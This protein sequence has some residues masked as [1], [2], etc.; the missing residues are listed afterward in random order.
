MKRFFVS[1]VLL[2][3]T[4][5]CRADHGRY[6]RGAS[7]GASYTYVCWSATYHGTYD[8]MVT[9]YDYKNT[10]GNQGIVVGNISQT[11]GVHLFEV[12]ILNGAYG[13][14]TLGDV[15]GLVNS[16]TAVNLN[17]FVG[18]DAY[19][20]SFFD[21][22]STNNIYHNNT[23]SGGVGAIG[24]PAYIW[25]KWDGSSGN[26]WVYLNGVIQNSGAPIA[27]GVTGPVWPAA[28][29]KMDEYIIQGNPAL[30]YG[31]GTGGLGWHN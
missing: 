16:Q 28:G 20:W 2:L 19:G 24:S 29:N 6:Y 5:L 31:G 14:G 27:T 26:I 11:S 23:G 3:V 22:G 15:V 12:K 10:T 1:V 9:A 4:V 21:Y 25:I 8:S 30:M 13:S 7:A 17:G 18:V